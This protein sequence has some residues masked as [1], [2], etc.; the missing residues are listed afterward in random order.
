MGGVKNPFA[1]GAG[2]ALFGA[3]EDE[4]ES[5]AARG[6]SPHPTPKPQGLP[7]AGETTPV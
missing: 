6:A 4:A 1:E 7:I 3:E 2:K 5:R